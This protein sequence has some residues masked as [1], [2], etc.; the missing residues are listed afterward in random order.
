MLILGDI[1]SDMMNV[2][3]RDIFHMGGDEVD[4][5]CYNDTKEVTDWMKANN[6]SLTADGF[7]RLWG[8][9]QEKG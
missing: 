2:F 6:Y 1:F 4:F 7:Y 3:D 9:F 5:R 8:E